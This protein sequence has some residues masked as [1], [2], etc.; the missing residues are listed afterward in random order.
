MGLMSHVYVGH[1]GACLHFFAEDGV[2][3]YETIDVL[4]CN[5]AEADTRICLHAKAIDDVGNANNISI[6]ASD[7]Y[8]AIITLHH[9]LAFSATLWMDTGTANAKNQRYVNLSAIAISIGS[10]TC[11]ALPAGLPCVHGDRLH[12]SDHSKGKCQGLQT[13]GEQQ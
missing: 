8:I 2:V 3:R 10:K 11:Q 5:Q 4:G 1:L 7:T 12:V 9:A 13:T 6:R